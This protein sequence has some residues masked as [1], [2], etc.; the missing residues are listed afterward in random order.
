MRLSEHAGDAMVL[1][2]DIPACCEILMVHI[3]R[4][5]PPFLGR[6]Y[7]KWRA[8]WSHGNESLDADGRK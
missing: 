6:M 1:N 5:A 2:S 3:L 7:R 8:H 4:D